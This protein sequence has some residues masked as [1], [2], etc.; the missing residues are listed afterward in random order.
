MRAMSGPVVKDVVLVG[1]GHAHVAVLRNFGMNPLPGVRLTLIAREPEAPYSGMLPGVVAGH[2]TTDAA[3]I[4]TG[5]L[6]RFAKARLYHDEAVG[7][8]LAARRVLCRGRPPVPYDLLS[9]NIG[10]RP[11]TGDVRGAA[12][13]AIPVKPMDGFLV[14]FE[15]LRARVL[16]GQSRRVLLVGGGAGGVELLLSVERRLRR[17]AAAAG[18]DVTSLSFALVSGAASLLPSFPPAFRARFSSVFAERGIAVH[19]GA[20]VSE[21]RADGVVVADARGE[22]VIAA[23]EVLWTTEA[24]P[25]TWLEDTGLELDNGFIRVDAFL[26][27]AGRDDVFAGGDTVAFGPRPIPRSGVY[28]VRAGPILA[29]NLR[30]TLTGSRLR[31]YKPQ[32]DALYIVSTGER[33]AVGTRNGV[34]VAGGWVWSVKDWID[35]RFI[36]RFTDLPEMKTASGEVASPLADSAALREL[37]SIAMRCGGC[38]AKVG[39][40][41]LSRALGRIDPAPRD[42]VLVGLDAPDDAAVVD[43]GGER[44][45]VQTVDYFRAIVDDPYTLRKDR[46]Q[47]F[48]SGDVYAMGGEPQTALAIATVPYGLEAKVEADLS[49]T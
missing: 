1:A 31:A 44:L 17:D 24:S 18:I 22:R 42:D 26:R 4:D 43:A 36:A 23:E 33:Y 21:V 14:R 40:T 48:A 7:L 39:A 15:A 30:A 34:T 49:A 27:A 16:A 28:A 9:L 35:R 13:H 25:A 19:V 11:N 45:S 6:A 3:Q 10:S 46:R 12:E 47:P 20:R 32:R 2:Y 38:G 41:V 5:A 8:D 29:A 37:S